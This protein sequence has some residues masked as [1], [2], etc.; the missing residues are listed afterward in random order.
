MGRNLRRSCSSSH[1]LKARGSS[2]PIMDEGEMATVASVSE[3]CE[4]EEDDV[5]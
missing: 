2:I 4:D 5:S 1:R 3:L